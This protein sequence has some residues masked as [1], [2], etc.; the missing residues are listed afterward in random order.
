MR[1]DLALSRPS[2]L[3][4]ALAMLVATRW[5]SWKAWGWFWSMWEPAVPLAALLLA[6][7]V[8][9]GLLLGAVVLTWRLANQDRGS[10]MA[11]LARAACIAACVAALSGTI[12]NIA[13][14]A[15][16]TAAP[17]PPP[18]TLPVDGRTAFLIGPITLRSYSALK[19]TLRQDNAITA[20]HLDSEGG[21]IGAAR[22]L[23]RL[24]ME[25][26]LDTH[27]TGICASACTLVFAAGTRRSM[28]RDAR[29]G[30]HG[31]L[32]HSRILTLDPEQEEARDAAFLVSRG[33]D[34]EF[35][36]RALAV[37]HSEMWFP[38][39]ANLRAAHVITE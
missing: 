34:P 1:T 23:A 3:L 16:R 8:D 33:I 29:L 18:V 25:A 22:G 27:A 39:P 9:I 32:L 35:A 30:F 2:A 6:I 28:A 5:L 11:F 19:T 13:R 21:H 20:L 36:A 7:A 37:P 15:T 4:L 38:S 14:N 24:V 17:A 10:G 12:D 31:Y 26:G